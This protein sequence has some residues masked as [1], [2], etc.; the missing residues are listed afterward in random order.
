ME[1]I[2]CMLVAWGICSIPYSSQVPR[3]SFLETLE[4]EKPFIF[5][6]NLRQV[7]ELQECH[8]KLQPEKSP[9]NHAS[10]LPSVSTHCSFEKK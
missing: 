5:I 8:C 9:G 1:W 4:K 7:G 2:H 6:N 3:C 10:I